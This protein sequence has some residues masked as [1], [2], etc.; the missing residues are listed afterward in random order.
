MIVFEVGEVFYDFD[1][2]IS[3]VIFWYVG[4]MGEIR[5]V[6]RGWNFEVWWGVV[7]GC[8][9][10]VVG[11]E[12]GGVFLGCVGVLCWGVVLVGV[13]VWILGV[14]VGFGWWRYDVR[15]NIW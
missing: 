4:F 13:V 2:E 8:E 3:F 11:E 6:L 10:F 7:E 12:Y 15:F 5:L 9:E 1:G 14:G